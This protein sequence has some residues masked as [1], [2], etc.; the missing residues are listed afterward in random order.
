MPADENRARV[1]E[2]DRMG[3]I[4]GLLADDSLLAFVIPVLYNIC[5]D[6]GE[7]KSPGV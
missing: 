5:V 1:V 7:S 4:V 2:S 3:S 6:Y